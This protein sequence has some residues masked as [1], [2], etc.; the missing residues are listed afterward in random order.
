MAIKNFL[1]DSWNY[2]SAEIATKGLAFISIPIFTRLMSPEEYG[3]LN[4][5]T[6]IAGLIIPFVTL[7]V[8]V[9]LGR[10]YFEKERSDFGEF[11]TTTSA[12][13]FG[14]LFIGF[15][16][17]LFFQTELAELTNL[18]VVAIPFLFP[19]A[20]MLMAFQ[21]PLIVL[22][23][24]R[25]SAELRRFTIIRGYG[26]FIL[27]VGIMYLLKENVYLGRLWANVIILISSVIWFVWRFR[28]IF[29]LNILKNHI[30]YM[31]NYGLPLLPANISAVL[32][33]EVDRIMINSYVGGDE[34]G[35]YSFA[36]N[37]SML[38]LVVSNALHYAFMPDYYTLM[39]RSE[40]GKIDSAFKLIITLI[41]VG[42]VGLILYGSV[43]GS[44]LGTASYHASLTMIPLI[45]IGQYFLSFVPLY[46]Q[47]ISYVKK[48]IY[49]TIS[50]VFAGIINVV[51]NAIFIPKY[52]AIAGAYTTVF[53]YLVQFIVV[54]IIVKYVIKIRCLDMSKFLLNIVQ[55]LIAI[56]AYYTLAY[57]ELSMLIDILVRTAVLVILTFTLLK[58]YHQKILQLVRK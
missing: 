13:S 58:P 51:L 48:T 27:A 1:K 49:S 24:Q 36:Y 56:V 55:V 44:F 30:V 10:Y 25:K 28:A 9:S 14:T 6:S 43:L 53:S 40:Y 21:I 17:S 33:M 11:F 19:T 15:L 32:L 45:V 46:K 54:Y 35:L 4:V 7:N 57:V 37:I 23:A 8:S 50:I 34:A 16:I 31:I 38:L 47:G 42:A 3:V 2:L 5:L 29:K 20:L 26:G 18:P 39:N 22:R 41:S 12:L 52:G